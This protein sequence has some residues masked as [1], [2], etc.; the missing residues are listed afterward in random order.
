MADW[1]LEPRKRGGKRPGAG[2]PKGSG[3][4]NPL[5]KVSQWEHGEFVAVDGEGYNL[6]DG[7]HIYALLQASSGEKLFD[8]DGLSLPA[9]LEFILKLRLAHPKAIFVGFNL[10]Y[11]ITKWFTGAG[12]LEVSVPL[13]RG[14]N[15][16]DWIFPFHVWY[17]K[18][19][20]WLSNA[21]TPTNVP[22]VGFE[23]DTLDPFYGF[24]VHM[25]PRKKF[26]AR[27]YGSPGTSL[28]DVPH[29]MGPHVV[30]YDVFSFFVERFD[31]VLEEWFPGDP[32]IALIREGKEHRAA[33][34][35][36]DFEGA[37][38][39]KMVLY[40]E[41]EVT[42]LADI[43]RKFW[44][45]ARRLEI[46][47][48]R[49]DGPGAIADALCRKYKVG[50]YRWSGPNPPYPPDFLKAVFHASYAG[51]AECIRYGCHH[52][53]VYYPD[54]NSAYPDAIRKL[55][56][57]RPGHYELKHLSGD[58][59]V[60]SRAPFI[61]YRVKWDFDGGDLFYPFPWRESSN[62]SL[63][64]PQRGESW[65]WHWEIEAA[66]R[67][68]EWAPRMEIMEAW[69]L[70]PTCSDE[71]FWFV[72]S[73]YAERKRL[74]DAGD[75]AEN[76]LRLALNSL[77]G[78]QAQQA[79]GTKE[80]PPLWWEPVWASM[81]TSQCRAKLLDAMRANRRGVIQV[82]TDGFLTTERPAFHESEELGGWKVKS[83]VAGIFAPTSGVYILKAKDGVET[84]R[85][86]GYNR[87]A[88]TPLA[89]IEGWALNK[90][91]IRAEGSRFW[92]LA[93]AITKSIT[94]KKSFARALSKVGQWETESRAIRLRPDAGNK[95]ED[96]N[97]AAH[98]E[99]GLVETAP[100]LP[101]YRRRVGMSAPGGPRW[102]YG[103]PGSAS[104]NEPEVIVD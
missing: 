15:K 52:G 101:F 64:F 81:I 93:A 25:I 82:A 50:R 39:D 49:W 96:V 100:T 73:L 35:R 102:W 84:V 7:R 45:L 2:R 90:P 83:Y 44:E 36:V 61:L 56:C 30:I 71:P 31:H 21:Q 70:T 4:L 77:Y 89:M 72:P 78:K 80:K 6:P 43:M 26:L 12:S 94:S 48:Y 47:I 65:L 20:R 8:I 3:K 22:V 63:Y 103:E 28:L 29:W 57:L 53:P 17:P 97:L 76:I 9:V 41:A 33:H 59:A 58:E 23:V 85:A 75:S 91:E 86:R 42:A 92:T 34:T 62:G 54:I 99:K 55:P 1:E 19:Q 18:E 98:P 51:R 14:L 88:I 67:E 69:S 27:D 40:N 74:K 5:R 60:A 95:R 37:A 66:A 87:S 104:P 38:L 46:R 10:S 11:D 16:G 79:G 13:V 24:Q 32:R 68:S